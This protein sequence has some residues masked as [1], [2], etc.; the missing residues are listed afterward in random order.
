[1][2][3]AKP[4]NQFQAGDHIE[5][6]SIQLTGV[7]RRRLLDLGFVPGAVVEL[8]QKSPLGDPIAYKVCGTQ[9]ALRQEE[10]VLITGKKRSAEERRSS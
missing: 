2:E 9:V 5:I 7:M 10:S 6:T 3:K 4:I 1:M 8:N